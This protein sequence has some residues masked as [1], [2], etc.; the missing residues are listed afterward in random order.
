MIVVFGLSSSCCTLSLEEADKGSVYL[1]GTSH[2]DQSLGGE[3]LKSVKPERQLGQQVHLR[4]PWS[5]GFYSLI[6]YGMCYGPFAL[7]QCHRVGSEVGQ[8]SYPSSCPS[9]EECAIPSLICL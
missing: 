6:Q 4:M 8:S 3:A 9:Q 2:A 7:L 1:W 5:S